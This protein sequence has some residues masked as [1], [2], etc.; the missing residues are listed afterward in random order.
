MKALVLCAGRGTRLRPLTYTR[1]KAA[2]PLAG[3]PVLAHILQ[4]L[5]RFGFADVG[6]VISP[7]QEELKA[8]GAASPGQRVE[9]IVQK[10]PLGIAH[11]VAAAGDYLGQ[12]DFLLYLGDN[13]TDE[14]L[15]PALGRFAADQ[16]DAIIAVRPVS[17]PSAYGIAEVDGD[18]VL[19]VWEKP[20]SPPG[21]LA[22]AGIYL[23]RPSV[24]TAIAQ[25]TPSARGE[26]EITD[27]L[28]GL[29]AGGRTILTHP[30]TGWWQD[31]GTPEGM[32]TANALLL[33]AIITE[34]APDVSLQNA[35]VQGRVVIGPGVKLENVRLRGPLLIGAGSVLRDAY[36][37]PY[38]SVGE[39][40][41]ISGAS[42]E[43]SIL[44]PGCRLEG[45]IFHLEDCLLGRGAVVEVKSG[46][47]VTLL[48]GDDGRLQIP[49]GRR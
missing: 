16:P 7:G 10:Q 34:I 43:H 8:L 3:R 46:R 15:L 20:A 19:R 17:N 21:N 13:L 32:L 26:Y 33:D 37:G 47:T 6:V 39:G 35:R 27:A 38:T 29:L 24:H 31:M 4:Y 25:L 45:P 48:L 44:L 5:H 42:L 49:R 11:A 23:L 1:S 14:N 22:I 2:L 41:Q 36:V 18:R 28:A 9:F 30:M 40:A 12:E